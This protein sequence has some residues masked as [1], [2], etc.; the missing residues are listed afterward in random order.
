MRKQKGSV[1]DGLIMER[2]LNK[3]YR[4]PVSCTS[5][6]PEEELAGVMSVCQIS[7]VPD[8]PAARG[9]DVGPVQL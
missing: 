7:E 3:I 4:K 6:L 5:A 1:R 9:R 2:W 8:D